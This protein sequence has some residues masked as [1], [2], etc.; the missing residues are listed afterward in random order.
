MIII[1]IRISQALYFQFITLYMV[2][3]YGKGGMIL[4]LITKS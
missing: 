4:Y 2:T 3:G 1:K